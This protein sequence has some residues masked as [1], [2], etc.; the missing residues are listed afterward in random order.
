MGVL[1]DLEA[2]TAEVPQDKVEK[3]KLALEAIRGSQW[4]GAD[5]VMSLLGLIGFCSQVLVPGGWRTCWTVV[6]LRIA[7]HHG[8][9]P[10]NGY[11]QAELDWWRRLL[12]DWNRVAMMVP[13]VWLEPENAAHLAPFTDASRTV[14]E[15][16]RA[17]S[18]GA[19]AVFGVLAM[20]FDFTADEIECLPICDLEGLVH[21][22]WLKMLCERC[23][24]QITGKRFV[25]W[26]DNQAF[27]GAVNDHKSNKPTL[28][29]LLEMLHELMARYSFDVRINF[30]ASEDN[31]AA[32]AA[33]RG[34][35]RRFYAYMQETVGVT[36]SD[37]VMLPVQEHARSLWSLKLRS[38]RTLQ[39]QM[40][41]SQGRV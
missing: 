31:V 19:G 3:T 9:A 33:S 1:L 30:V 12:M 4:V 13:Q 34:E 20:Q 18:G 32:D 37:I 23:P 7:V 8:H 14:G 26:C 40:T 10:M 41:G 16:G 22:L 17:V 39:G 36:K 11:W 21:V 2:E 6:A 15:D 5:K 38:M 28:A 25:T 27:V 35:W 29:F 24:E